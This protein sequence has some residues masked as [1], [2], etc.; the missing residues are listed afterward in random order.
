MLNKDLIRFKQ[1]LS[2]VQQNPASER[3]ALLA[4]CH[5]TCNFL[6]TATFLQRPHMPVQNLQVVVVRFLTLYK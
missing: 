5:I 1:S 2:R 6:K 3:Q 4:G